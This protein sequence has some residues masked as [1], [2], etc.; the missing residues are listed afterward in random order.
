[1]SNDY[2]KKM[3]EAKKRMQE[4]FTPRR[5]DGLIQPVTFYDENMDDMSIP[6]VDR[7]DKGL[8]RPMTFADS[9]LDGKTPEFLKYKDGSCMLASPET[10]EKIQNSNSEY[11]PYIVNGY[12][13]QFDNPIYNL[14][15]EQYNRMMLGQAVQNTPVYQDLYRQGG[16]SNVLQ[17][18]CLANPAERS[19]PNAAS[20]TDTAKQAVQDAPVAAPDHALDSPDGFD[21]SEHVFAYESLGLYVDNKKASRPTKLTNFVV[22]A[23]EHRICIPRRL[24][25]NPV[26]EYLLQVTCNTTRRMM[27]ISA[28]NIDDIVHSIQRKMPSCVVSA[29]AARAVPLITNF[30]RK[31]LDELPTCTYIQRTGFQNLEGH[32]V[33]VH[34]GAAAPV[35]GYVF[36][37]GLTIPHDGA[38]T[39]DQAFN[40]ALGFLSL[41]E[42]SMLM[43][44]MLLSVHLGM[45]FQLFEAAE[46]TPRFL[47][48]LNGRTGSLKTST[49]L[50]LLRQFQQSKTTPE[51]SFKDT[52]T[53][54]EIRMGELNGRCCLI[55]DYRNP[56]AAFDGKKSLSTLEAVIR[57]VGD[58]I[59]KSRSNPSLGKA[60]EFH[61][62]GVVVLTGEG[63]GGA[64]ST[65]LRYLA[66]SISKDD[67]HGNRLRIYQDNP[68]LLWSHYYYFLDFCGKAAEEIIQFIRENLNPLRAEYRQHINEL[69]MV[70]CAT[71]LTLVGKILLT[72]G[73]RIHALTEEAACQ[74]D[75]QLRDSILAAVTASTAV[76]QS[77]DPL[78][79]YLRALEDLIDHGDLSIAR[80]PEGYRGELHV[81]FIQ[82]GELWLKEK[83]VFPKICAYWANVGIP[84]T[85]PASD[86]KVLLADSGL[87]QV[88][89]EG[90]KKLYVRK[91]KLP[92]RPR[93][94]VFSIQKSREY[95]E[96]HGNDL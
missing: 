81:G 19:Q 64:Q 45:L 31:Q 91:S 87:L 48:F 75:V 16:L 29:N 61:P 78:A 8:I 51:A 59:S 89:R 25:E 56:K 30:I 70:D 79:Q 90:S 15:A 3:E 36:E 17:N 5:K 69:R 83:F 88:S 42:R 18:I 10:L 35:P 96:K 49:C 66:I 84:F 85:P 62:T 34:D 63:I 52:Q 68:M 6:Y 24:E 55:D 74:L 92:G 38:T 71:L 11:K 77:L 80:T 50:A 21:E 72:Y 1:M 2:E 43:V 54:L 65:A 32:W 27:S 41:S 73:V 53:S 7:T 37:T 93:F 14:S 39:P 47:L 28:E 57:F 58:Q 22:N 76:A 95:L 67:I 12:V 9:F 13:C 86:I 33:Y 23:V 82:D 44:P 40:N 60:I 94:L 20:V 46:A 26:E 4:A